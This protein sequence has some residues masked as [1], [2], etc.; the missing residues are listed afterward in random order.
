VN[1]W[2]PQLRA[3]IR[4]AAR[5]FAQSLA[6]RHYESL[7]ANPTVLF[8]IRHGNFVQPSLEAILRNPR[9]LQ[10]FNARNRTQAALPEA[11]R[12]HS[13]NVDSSNSSTALLMNIACFPGVSLSDLF[14][15]DSSAAPEFDVRY[16][17]AGERSSELG[18][19]ELDMTLGEHFHAEAKLA[20]E[21]FGYATEEQ[22]LAYE[23]FEA[24]FKRELLTFEDGHFYDYQLIRNVLAA[25]QRHGKFVLLYDARRPDL[26]ARW[27]VVTAAIVDET[28]RGA[29]RAMTWQQI[30]A[31]L[32]GELRTFLDDKY[33]FVG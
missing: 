12:D 28:L 22:V 1:K 19:T 13:R 7:G 10:V 9:W 33:G 21:N 14:E 24:V 15:A 27:E 16:R 20:E 3:A 11:V 17:V 23:R 30:S 25:D 8:P 6:P 32:E 29:C 26:A 31:G 4:E 2:V 5:S 18:W